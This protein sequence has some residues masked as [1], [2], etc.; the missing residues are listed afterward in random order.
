M[1]TNNFANAQSSGITT[2]TTVYTS[3][4]GQD[5]IML[6]LDIANTTAASVDVDVRIYDNSATTNCYLV[7]ATPILAGSSMKV[8]S[9]Q[10]VVLEGNDY[11]TV[12]ATGAVDAICSILED[13]N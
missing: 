6:E 8:I 1:A 10:K 11:I 12:T 3:P 13:V 5:S 9:G 2:A 7:K 4:N